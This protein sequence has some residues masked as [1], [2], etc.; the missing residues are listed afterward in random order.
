MSRCSRFVRASTSRAS[1]S[2]S[3]RTL[4]KAASKASQPQQPKTSWQRPV[5]AGRIPAYDESLKFLAADASAKKAKLAELK[6]KS[7][8]ADARELEKLEVDSEVNDP[9]VR[10]NFR[11]GK[12]SGLA[13]YFDRG[14][15]SLD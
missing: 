3:A 14:S 7:S 13:H 15:H 4:D 9:E 2:T 10:W 5:E 12:G 8:E 6:K 11:H 1:F